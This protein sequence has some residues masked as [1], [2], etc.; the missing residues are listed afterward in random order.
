MQE[1]GKDN[2][3]KKK[4]KLGD[5]LVEQ[6]VITNDQLMEALTKQKVTKSRLGA[7]LIEM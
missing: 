4:K 5:V 2:I 3:L 1:N 7:T 6:G